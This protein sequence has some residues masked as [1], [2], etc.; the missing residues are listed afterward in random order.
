MLTI[1]EAMNLPALKGTKLIAG[2]KGRDNP[3]NWVT[4]I[5]IIEDISR[6]NEGEFI[7]TTG[8]GLI[9]NPVYID[10]LTEL[11][12]SGRLSGLAFH[13]GFYLQSIPEALT[14]AADEHHLP[15]IEIPKS[16]NFSTITKTIVEEIGNEQMRL[17]QDSLKIH[18]EM[19]K[20]ALNNKGLDEVLKRISNLTHSTFLVFNDIGELQAVENIH[21]DFVS[22]TEEY[23][24]VSEE[25]HS[26]ASLFEMINNHTPGEP[27]KIAN[28]YCFSTP[29]S[30]ES[31]TYGYL[32]ALQHK[33]FWSEM[34]SIIMDHVSTLV[35]IE[36]VKQYAVEETRVRLKGELAEEILL[37]D[38]FNKEAALKRGT[39]LGYDLSK[40]HAV[41]YLRIHVKED[42]R[43]RINEDLSSH[44]HYVAA[45]TLQHS[46]RQYIILPKAEE[47][48]ALVQVDFYDKINE[49]DGLKNISAKIQDRWTVNFKQQLTIG[50]GNGYRQ[51][52]E[53]SQ[54][55]K[56]AEYAVRY[57]PLFLNGP[58]VVHFDE[59]GFYQMLIRMQEA[60]IS[61]KVFYETHLGN[62]LVNKQHR[63][64][65][66]LTLEVYLAHNCNIQQAASSLFIHRHTL[67]YRLSQI[68]KYTGLSLQSPDDRFNLHL[69]ILAY[70][71]A[72]MQSSD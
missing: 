29:V 39:K 27:I 34:D 41:L 54:S 16:I 15:L 44:L 9:D 40:P 30:A 4:T 12:K 18:K 10:R 11:I 33:P 45:Q 2:K 5:E 52:N 56:E 42:E 61:L 63:T 37:K 32:V 53:V 28:F 26:A 57:A 8:Y 71:F 36:L 17:L 47:L 49:K 21:Q 20:L 7:V 70:K 14:D 50:I 59:L 22:V 3:I 1:Y 62:L 35:G 24:T 55:A 58:S 43:Y 25:K 38:K 68:E 19:T 67:K 69:A 31:F 72:G 23:V 51:L 66:I 65:L 48:Y 13:T 60:G 46:G 64:D 6:F